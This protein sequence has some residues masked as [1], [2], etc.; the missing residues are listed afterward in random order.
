[1]INERDPQAALGGHA[2]AEQT[3]CTGTD[4]DRIKS[5]KHGPSPG[6][7]PIRNGPDDTDET[8]RAS[9]FLVH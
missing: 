1:M 4:D 2:R 8:L 9:A 5:R 3:R 7:K 6:L